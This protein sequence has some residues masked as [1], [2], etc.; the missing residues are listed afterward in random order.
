MITH[1]FLRRFGRA[2][3]AYPALSLAD[4]RSV[5]ET[6]IKDASNAEEVEPLEFPF[7]AL[8]P[9][10]DREQHELQQV[11]FLGMQFELELP[12]SLSKVLPEPVRSLIDASTPTLRAA[13]H[14]SGPVCVAIP[15]SYDSPLAYTSP[16]VTGGQGESQ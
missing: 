6:L 2:G 7:C 5:Q 15:S 8:P 16:V 13:P 12:K 1:N 11:R 3:F 9:V 4:D 14:S 10:L